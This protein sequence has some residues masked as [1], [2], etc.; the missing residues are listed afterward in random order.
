MNQQAIK[1]KTN[2]MLTLF[3][4]EGKVIGWV[5][6]RGP[7]GVEAFDADERSIGLFKN[8]YNAAGAISRSFN[9]SRT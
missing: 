8:E 5:L 2:A 3:D 9:S 6:N 4:Q 7:A 1:S